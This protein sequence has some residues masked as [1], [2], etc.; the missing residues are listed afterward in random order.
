MPSKAASSGLLPANLSSMKNKT[1]LRPTKKASD[2]D[3]QAETQ[4]LEPHRCRLD[5]ELYLLQCLEEAILGKDLPRLTHDIPGVTGPVII[6]GR[7]TLWPRQHTPKEAS[8]QE[9]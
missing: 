1:G 2:D 8:S 4:Q 7:A 5:V 6:P 9:T 3:N